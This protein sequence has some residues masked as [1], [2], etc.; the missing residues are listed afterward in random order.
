MKFWTETR[1]RSYRERERNFRYDDV[2]RVLL[3]WSSSDESYI[4]STFG[5][6]GKHFNDWSFFIF[7]FF[8][9]FTIWGKFWKPKIPLS[10]SYRNPFHGISHTL[11]YILLII[12]SVLLLA[13][14]LLVTVKFIFFKFIW[15]F[16]LLCCLDWVILKKFWV[17]SEQ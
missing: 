2:S 16:L 10:S 14:E 11:L 5:S 9:F 17:R 8:F 15:V 3:Q 12:T 4:D 1:D 7:I 6:V 13:I